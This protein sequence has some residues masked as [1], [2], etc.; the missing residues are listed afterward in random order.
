[1]EIIDGRAVSCR[2]PSPRPGE[3]GLVREHDG[4]HPIA[5]VQLAEHLR[6][7]GLHVALPA[8]RRRSALLSIAVHSA[9]TLF[10]LVLL[11]GLVLR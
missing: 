10:F 8:K 7:V 2:S 4:L 1:M 11:F 5:E 9:Q 3:P 6:H